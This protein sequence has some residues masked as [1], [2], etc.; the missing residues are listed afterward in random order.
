MSEQ[1]IR[2][3]G[4]DIGVDLIFSV[5]M[6]TH[7]YVWSPEL[8]IKCLFPLVSTRLVLNMAEPGAE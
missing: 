2:K 3:E 6:Y 8:T 1:Q 7:T 4:G 5:C